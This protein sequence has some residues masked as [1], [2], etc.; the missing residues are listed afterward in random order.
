MAEMLEKDLS[1]LL[2]NFFLVRWDQVVLIYEEKLGNLKWI[3][4]NCRCRQGSVID[5]IIFNESLKQ[6]KSPIKQILYTNIQK[7]QIRV[8]KQVPLKHEQALVFKSI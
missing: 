5:E 4:R 3:L 6:I 7:K 8:D 1:C 2:V